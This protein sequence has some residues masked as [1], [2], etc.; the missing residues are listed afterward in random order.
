MIINKNKLKKLIPF[1]IVLILIV[2]ILLP[3]GQ[4]I[5]VEHIDGIEKGPSFKPVIPLKKTTFVNF[6][7]EKLLDDYA[8]LA[9]IPTAIF[10]SDGK[11]YSYPLQLSHL[12]QQE[13]HGMLHNF[14]LIE[15]NLTDNLVLRQ[16]LE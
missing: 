12:S 7:T 11:L 3:I 6:D 13:A 4:A 1:L 16:H 10:S 9:S 2:S 14:H 8:Y 5:D 15:D